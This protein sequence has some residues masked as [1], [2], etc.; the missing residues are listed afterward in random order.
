MPIQAN[1]I[2]EVS[3][4]RALAA[5]AETQARLTLD[6]A[7]AQAFEQMAS[8]YRAKAEKLESAVLMPGASACDNNQ[9]IG[10]GDQPFHPQVSCVP[11]LGQ[12]T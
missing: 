10:R 1:W 8:N 11:S 5:I 3:E 7:A 12:R 2:A 6:R 9:V 4:L